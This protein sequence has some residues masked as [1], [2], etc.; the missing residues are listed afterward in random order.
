[1]DPKIHR[2]KTSLE[3]KAIELKEGFRITEDFKQK[4]TLAI[5]DFM[6]FHNAKTLELAKK[7]SKF[8]N[9]LFT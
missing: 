4:L 2:D 8:N 9:R 5:Q 6:K 1:L 3:R 7:C